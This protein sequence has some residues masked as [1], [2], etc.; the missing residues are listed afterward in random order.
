M[1]QQ[2]S[3]KFGYSESTHF[4]GVRLAFN[5]S[6]NRNSAKNCELD[7]NRTKRTKDC[8]SLLDTVKFLLFLPKEHFGL[9][10]ALPHLNGDIITELL[11]ADAGKTEVNVSF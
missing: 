11:K 5:S 9:A 2:V 10:K 7:M 6:L 3:G 1:M 4:Y 8:G